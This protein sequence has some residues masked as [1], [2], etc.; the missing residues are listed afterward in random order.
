AKCEL[1]DDGVHRCSCPDGYA[2]D[3]NRCFG[4]LLDELDMNFQFYSFFKLIQKF[5]H[6]SEDLS[7]NLTIL[8]PS[9][10]AIRNMS[11]ADNSFWTTRH[12]LPHFLRS[13]IH[14]LITLTVGF[15]M[16]RFYFSQNRSKS[17]WE[18]K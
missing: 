7:G 5:G 16:H 11:E 12:R 8:A 1:K 14:T 18:I 15:Y 6:S 3:G 17:L 4:F 13:G 9:R 2:G 10:E